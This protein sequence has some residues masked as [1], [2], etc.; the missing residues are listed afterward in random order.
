[1]QDHIGG[2]LAGL[3]GL[4]ATELLSVIERNRW[5]PCSGTTGLHVA[6]NVVVM[7]W[8]LHES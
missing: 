7:R 8:I 3:S 2:R 5:S 1:M 6:E 4:H